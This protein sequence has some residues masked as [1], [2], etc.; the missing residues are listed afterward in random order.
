MTV[1]DAPGGDI[2]APPDAAVPPLSAMMQ[3]NYIK[4]SNT[5]TNDNF[6]S[7]IVLS[8]DGTTLVIAAPYEA[9]ASGQ[10]DDSASAA[11]A[12]YVFTRTGTSW[13][14]QAYLKASN[15][16]ANDRFGTALAL[17]ADGS[18]LAV[19]ASG[20]DSAAVGING[21]QANEAA[22]GSGAVYVYTRA[23]TAWT[24]QAYIKASNTEANDEFGVSIAL[25]S[26]GS[27]LAV[28]ANGEDSQGFGNQT[29]NTMAQAG[30]A[31]VFVRTG[32]TWN[33]QAYLKASNPGAGDRFGGAVALSGDGATLAVGAYFESSGSVGVNGAQNEAIVVSGAVYVLT[34]VGTT[35]SHQ[36]FVKASN[37]GSGDLF[38]STVAL[39]TDG[40]T[41]AVGA[42]G[43]E[44]AAPGINGNQADNTAPQ[45]GAVYT[46]T[47]TGTT[48]SQQAYIK[49]SNPGANDLFSRSGLSLSG[50]GSILVVG[51]FWEDGADVGINGN[52]ADNSASEAGAAYVYMRSGT[53]WSQSYYVKASNAALTDRFS[54]GIGISGDGATL[55]IGAPLED[56][57]AVGLEGNQADNATQESGAVYV[58]R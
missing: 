40:T 33:Q 51:A 46:F 47:R 2:D 19:S 3:R 35:W 52:D 24:Q 13:T 42:S 28:G 18:M 11:G 8:A 55:A 1:I 16:A 31:Y 26:D 37:T 10:A 32:T 29:D 20:E 14:Q 27:T 50:N 12:V 25:S 34:R 54:I 45:A 36:A 4:A 48:W 49:A 17:S 43:E 56:S 58:F 57:S 7:T 22:L 23:G 38:G 6:G 5:G 15:P 30:A 39:S 44:S 21:N 53:T 41:L 9:S